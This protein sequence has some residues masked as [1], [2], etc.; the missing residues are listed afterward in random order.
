MLQTPKKLMTLTLS[1][2]LLAACGGADPGPAPSLPA[3]PEGRPVFVNYW[4]EWCAPCREEIPELN[5]FAA[6]NRGRMVLYGV[7]FDAASGDELRRQELAL[8]IE[9]PTLEVDPG[10]SLG[11]PLP[12]VLPVT[13]VLDGDGKLITQLAG[14]QTLATLEEALAL[15]LEEGEK[16]P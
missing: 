11:L 7:N 13:R 6:A 5:E 8:G 2:V 4:A 12:M 3:N 1:A 10:I 9:F 16:Q 15:A 14:V